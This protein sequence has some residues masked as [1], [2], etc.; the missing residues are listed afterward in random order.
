MVHVNKHSLRSVYAE[1]AAV[2]IPS[3]RLQVRFSTWSCIKPQDNETNTVLQELHNERKSDSACWTADQF[4]Q[5]NNDVTVNVVAGSCLHYPVCT[6]TG[7]HARTVQL[8]AVVCLLPC[9]WQYGE[10][11]LSTVLAWLT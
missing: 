9:P 1:C 11:L 3:V 2:K 4:S 7:C 5:K 10:A 8:P 6:C